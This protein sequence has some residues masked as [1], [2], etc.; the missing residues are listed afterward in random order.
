MLPFYL[1]Q[2][3]GIL[4][5]EDIGRCCFFPGHAKNA[6][7][8][9]PFVDGWFELW[10][11]YEKWLK[12]NAAGTQE[13]RAKTHEK[14]WSEKD[15]RGISVRASAMGKLGAKPKLEERSTTPKIG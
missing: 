11:L 9:G 12:I 15:D 6:L 5:S 10:D 8:N 14:L 2:Y 4:Q 3:A 1:H 7:I 13:S